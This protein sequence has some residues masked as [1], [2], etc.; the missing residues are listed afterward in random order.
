MAKTHPLTFAFVYPE[1]EVI[2]PSNLAECLCI[3]RAR[4][5]QMSA[6]EGQKDNALLMICHH[7]TFRNSMAKTHP[8]TFACVY[9]KAK[10]HQ[11]K[12]Y[13][14]N[15]PHTFACLCPEAEVIQPLNLT[16]FFRTTRAKASVLL[17]VEGLK[18]IV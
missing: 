11:S 9:P 7:A 10:L 4:F 5:H 2:Q 16:E 1:A 13:N 18:L 3:T 12:F 14:L 6:G 17:V 8:H 15:I